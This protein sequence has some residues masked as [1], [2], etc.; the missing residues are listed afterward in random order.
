MPDNDERDAALL[1]VM[2]RGLER[3]LTRLVKVGVGLVQ[4]DEPRVAVDG[5][6]QPDALPLTAGK[7][8]P[9]FADLGLVPVGK[10]LDHFMGMAEGV[11]AC[12]GNF[13]YFPNILQ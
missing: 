5:A 9:A 1:P 2:N 6:R 13:A 12:S 7:P 11:S 8:R 4:D 10:A 3:R